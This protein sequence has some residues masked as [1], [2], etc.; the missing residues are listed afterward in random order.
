MFRDVWATY[1]HRLS[2]D[3]SPKHGLCPRGEDSWCCFQ[4]SLVT[5]EPYRHT[6]SIPHAVMKCIRPVYEDLS[7]KNLLRKCLH[8]KTQN[9]NESFNNV[10]W[11]RLPT[12]VFVGL[13]TLKVGVWDAVITYNTGYLGRVKVLQELF[14]D[15]GANCVLG[16]KV[17]DEVRRR[18]ADKSSEEMEKKARRANRNL[19]RKLEEEEEEEQVYGP[20]IADI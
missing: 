17:L 7:N 18:K 10:V 2:T 11:S 5:K 12:R 14:S 20:G 9:P 13:E 4:K 15:A 3:E 6:K 1:F 8:G 19:K 16:F